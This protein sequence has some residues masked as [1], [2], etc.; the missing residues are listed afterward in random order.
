MDYW[1]KRTTPQGKV[2]YGNSIT[3]ETTWDYNEIDISTGH[4]VSS[5]HRYSSTTPYLMF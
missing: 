3:H 5:N 2:Y 1:M 4:L